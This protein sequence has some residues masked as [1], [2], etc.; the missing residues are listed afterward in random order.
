MSRARDGVVPRGERGREA[1]RIP[2]RIEPMANPT[3]P[4]RRVGSPPFG[5]HITQTRFRL[6]IAAL[7]VAF[8]V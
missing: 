5:D 7:A 1:T 4:T 3:A 8:A 2:G 6:A